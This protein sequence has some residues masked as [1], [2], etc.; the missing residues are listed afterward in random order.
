MKMKKFLDRY[1]FS[2][3]G[4]QL[5]F[6][7]VIILLFSLAGTV[8]RN[9]VTG[10]SEADIYSQ[11]FWG[12]RQIT[13]GGSMAGTLD[14]LDE[15]AKES[16]NT[17]AAPVV[18]AVALISWLIGM[19]LYGFVAGAVAN[20]F[21]GRKEKIDAGVVRYKFRNHGL[22]I[23][24]DF[25]GVACVKALLAECEEV[26]VV[27]IVAAEDIRGELERELDGA[28]LKRVYFYNGQISSDEDLLRDCQPERSRR[29][30][31]LGERGESNN[32]GSNLHLERLVRRCV[33]RASAD[34]RDP[35]ATIKVNLHIENPILYAQ[36]LTVP[37]EGFAEN[38]NRIDLEPFNYYES[39]AW[40][41][42]SAKNAGDGVPGR[43]GD[44]YLPLRHRP[45][46]A[47]V[48]L[49]ILGAGPMGQAMAR[50]AMPLMNYGAESRC[51]RI[52]VFDADP[53]ACLCLPERRILDALPETEAVFKNVDGA[54]DEANELMLTA[55]A[56]PKTAVTIVIATP[57]A[58]AAVQSYLGLPNALRRMDVS[59][60]VWQ[61]TLAG[62]CPS[63]AFLQTGGDR[64]KLRFFGMTDILPWTDPARQ[65]GGSAVNY[66]YDIAFKC[67]GVPQV[68]LP[69]A[70][71]ANL[72]DVAKSVWEPGLASKRWGG[73]ERWK[74]WS[75]VNC[76]D[77]FRERA[78]AFPNFATDVSVRER[79]LR[80]EHNRW[81]TERLLAGW[82][83]C[84][85]PAGKAEAAALKETFYHW[86]MVP[87]EQLD[88]FTKDL[89]KVSAA[90]MVALGFDGAS[91]A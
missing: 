79:M 35:C 70:D 25:Q 12:F 63:K 56:D 45:D 34:L 41:C 90:A 67:D 58:D 19:V 76:A 32:N 27:S 68:A 75:S 52:T 57:G 37:R 5:L 36:A 66:F 14:G 61:P 59:V 62:M 33:E 84:A 4:L 10:H 18:L 15:V 24:W 16:R 86:D 60:L 49:F 77:A 88:D 51:C 38:D 74:R 65:A 40:R 11:V 54:S 42:W 31:I 46:A 22:V 28:Q 7:I 83:P 23:G 1:L 80:A 43:C 89:D 20:A 71:A 3:I 85:K 47:R 44:A 26:L 29:V 81:W 39:W 78:A 21:A 17:L 48:E 69:K 13:D 30:V 55:A 9:W 64:A 6:S 72:A 50:F 8:L 53:G 2:R 82:V 91:C 87:F 73:M